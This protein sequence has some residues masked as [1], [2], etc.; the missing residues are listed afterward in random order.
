MNSEQIRRKY[1]LVIKLSTRRLLKLTYLDRNI[2]KKQSQ[3]L[4]IKL[5]ILLNG[6]QNAFSFCCQMKIYTIDLV[7]MCFYDA[8]VDLSCG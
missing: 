8:Q 6:K 2:K 3:S 7:C 1:E 4:C 5:I